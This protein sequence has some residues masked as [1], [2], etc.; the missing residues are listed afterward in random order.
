M[1]L[2][3]TVLGPK[4]CRINCVTPFIDPNKYQEYIQPEDE[5][6]L[7]LFINYNEDRQVSTSEHL[8]LSI[9]DSS[10]S[11]EHFIIIETIGTYH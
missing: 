9:T 3:V 5:L 8:N 4:L 11:E 6:G 2:F 10:L 7:T 1:F